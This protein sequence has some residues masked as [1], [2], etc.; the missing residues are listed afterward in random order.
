[1][2]EYNIVKHCILC[3]AR[4]VVGRGQAKRNYCDACER[5]ENERES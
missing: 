5:R 1:M 3:K 2:V 4:F